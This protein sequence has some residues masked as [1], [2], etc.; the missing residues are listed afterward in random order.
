MKIIIKPLLILSIVLNAFLFFLIIQNNNDSENTKFD[1]SDA[2]TTV[3]MMD[4]KN[5]SIKQLQT[6]LD[7]LMNEYLE[8]LNGGESELDQTENSKAFE[9][10]YEDIEVFIDSHCGFIS[11]KY[12]GGTLEGLTFLSC[13]ESV[14]ENLLDYYSTLKTQ[15]QENTIT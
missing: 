6:K 3:N 4:C 15:S 13:K 1:C 10:S 5:E 2:I 8:S 14:L 9:K 7:L 12:L 11:R